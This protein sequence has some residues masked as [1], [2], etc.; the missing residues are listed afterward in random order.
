MS[1]LCIR[2]PKL[3]GSSI[4]D[5]IPQVGQCPN[6]CLE[7]FYNAEGFFTDKTEPLLPSLDE[8]GDSVVRVNSGHDSNIQ[9]DLVI[10]TTKIYPKKFYNTSLPKFDFPGPV[11]FTCNGRDTDYSALMVADTTNVMMVRFRSNLWNLDLLG[12]V[13]EYYGIKKKIPITL[14]FM[15]YRDE[16]HIPEHYQKLYVKKVHILNSYYVL[17]EEIKQEIG[18]QF[19]YL[20]KLVGLCGS[21]KS[22]FCKDCY[23]CLY[24]FERFTGSREFKQVLENFYKNRI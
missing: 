15:R 3:E 9:R 6:G 16:N 17:D 11:V 18:E 8:V 19:K 10:E 14:T 20:G 22:S 21:Y 1:K 23:R 13:I 12:E 7:C 5:C 4:I 2:N 24:C